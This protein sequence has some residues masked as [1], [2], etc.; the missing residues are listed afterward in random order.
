MASSLV[1]NVRRQQP[2]LVAPAK[3]TPHEFKPVSDIDDQEGLRFQT[4]SVQIYRNHVALRGLNLSQL[5][6]KGLA[7]ALVFYYPLA[8]RLRARPGGKLV[9]E[10][11][12][13]GVLFIVA[14][15]DVRLEQLG[16][17]PQPPFPCIDELLYDVPGSGAIV[18]C[19]LLLIQL[20]HL[21]CGGF[22]LGLR[23][24]H[25]MCDN[26]GIVKFMHAVAEMII[27]ARAPS[28]T[29]VWQR[30][31]LD[32][33]QPPRIT[34]AHQEY[35][36]KEE[37]HHPNA[38]SLLAADQMLQRCFFFGAR[39]IATLRNLLPP[40]LRSCTTTF[41]LLTACL[42]RC[43]TA[44]IAPA[45]D[46]EVRVLCVVNTRAKYNPPL[47]TGY[48]GNVVAFPA[49]VSPAGKLCQS[50]VEY[51]V[52]LV[53][54]AK[55]DAT[56]EYMQS[57]ADLMVVKE[58]PPFKVVRTW[59]VSDLTR[60]GSG[61]VDF[62]W[63]V[64]VYSGPPKSVVG[65]NPGM[66]SFYVPFRNGKGEEGLV[67]LVCLP[68]PEMEKFSI[69]VDSMVDDTNKEKLPVAELVQPLYLPVGE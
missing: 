11:T 8:G 22:I 51:A 14:E 47:P 29:P 17:A 63:G 16:D 3:P 69:E 64:P 61:L 55:A 34:C 27:G 44:A 41:E 49:A 57:V 20:T 36:Y 30:E 32:A 60:G 67:A 62:G 39:E 1:F 4:P 65:E 7:E 40:H 45:P 5:I 42:W 24:N 33:R 31:L 48:Y 6:Q 54:K 68:E 18:D 19:P 59:M 21:K 66:L 53:K 46:E 43:R 50:P 9:V 12:G 23:F 35:E 10:C 25:V 52:E 15:A 37:A 2:V 13:E 56:R 28:I 38:A 58:R 26:A